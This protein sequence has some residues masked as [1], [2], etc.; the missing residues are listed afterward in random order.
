M[1]FVTHLANRFRQA[2]EQM[3]APNVVNYSFP[4]ATGSAGF[5]TGSSLVVGSSAMTRVWAPL[6]CGLVCGVEALVPKYR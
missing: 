6:V 3:L 5:T 1:M 4:P 2:S